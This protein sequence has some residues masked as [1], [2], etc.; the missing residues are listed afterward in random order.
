MEKVTEKKQ[1]SLKGW[2]YVKG[3][4][5]AVVTPVVAVIIQ[6]LDAG[7]LTLDWLTIRTVA[8]S[9]LFAYLSKQFFEPSKVVVEKPEKDTVTRVKRAVR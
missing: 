2:D 1:F 7:E 6:T 8:A 5:L 3:L 4:I 9:A